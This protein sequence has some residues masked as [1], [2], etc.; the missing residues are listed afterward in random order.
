MASRLIRWTLFLAAISAFGGFS[1]SIAAV[2]AEEGCGKIA[3]G[4]GHG[5]ILWVENAI[6]V[7]GT[8]APNLSDPYKSISAI[9]RETQRAATLDA[10]RKISEILAGVSISGDRLAADSP[11]ILARIQAYVPQ[12]VICKSKFYADGGIDIVVRVPLAGN[13]AR[14]L[15]PEAGTRIA[16]S[17]SKYTGLV[18]DARDLAFTPA[19]APRL[20]APDGK[21]LFS[22]ENVKAE[23]ITKRAAVQYVNHPGDIK[24]Q[25]VGKNPL[26][27]RAIGLGFLSP[28]D[29]VLNPKSIPDL[30]DSPAFLGDGKVVIITAS[31]RRLE[32][33]HLA[34][35]VE[36]HRID[37]EQKIALA[38]GFGKVDFSGKEDTA[39]RLRMMERAAEV[40]AQNKLL[41]VLLGLK[42][43][44]TK[45]LKQVPN[46]PKY[47]RGVLK[48][49]VRCS[50]K[51]YSDGTAE[52]VLAA[53]MDGL[54]VKGADLGQAGGPSMAFLESDPSGLIVDASGLNFTPVLAPQLAGPDGAVFYNH[55]VIARGYAHR[56]G[57][58]GY[59]SS[60]E[61]AK[62]DTRIG[63]NPIIVRAAR[64]EESSS[65]LV[66][67]A[68]DAERLND[69][70]NLTGLFRQGR[71][72]IV[73]ENTIQR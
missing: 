4:I 59:R 26:R 28:S 52:V 36:D 57:V 63:Q 70:A 42:I 18:I 56:Y 31:V 45:A 17:K 41:A 73:T 3:E 25:M 13:L 39:V 54:A 27:V 20:L 24:K 22:Q 53:R 16:A 32:C 10:Y 69:L 40:D 66:L 55:K 58:V 64:V 43:N 12:P 23:V 34:A 60:A 44:S 48:N 50:A 62:S 61:V 7:Q 33:K 6:I 14:A 51:Y 15:L 46:A 72:L 71:V 8:A 67:T 30:I 5:G 68:K 1:F 49:A 29:L 2:T 65:R 38:R 47:T 19:F 37:W 11:Q 9:K 21:I 35:K